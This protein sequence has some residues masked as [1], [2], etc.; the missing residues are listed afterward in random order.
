MKKSFLSFILITAFTVLPAVAQTQNTE[1]SIQVNDK[2]TIGTRRAYEC[3][4]LIAHLAGFQEFNLADYQQYYKPYDDYFSQFMKDKRVVNAIS[5]YKKIRNYGFSYDA[6]ANFATYLSSDCHSFRTTDEKILK[7]NIQNRCGDIKELQQVIADFYDATDFE[8]FYQ[9]QLP[10][11]EQIAQY[12]YSYKDTMITGLNELEKYYRAEV[13]GIFI[14]ASFLTGP[15][16]FG[17]SFTDGK[18]TWFEPQYGAGYFDANLFIHELS[19]PF[20]NKA[21]DEIIKNKKIMKLV[22]KDFKGEKKKIMQDQAYGY[23]ETYLYELFNR[24]NTNNILKGFCDEIYVARSI[25]YDKKRRFDEIAEVTEILDRYMLGDYENIYAFLP[26]LEKEYI[27][28]LQT[29]DTKPKPFKLSDDDTSSFVFLGKTY[30]AEYCGMQDLTGF[31]DYVCRKY[32]RLKDAYQNVCN[33]SV[34]DYLP[35]NN[36]PFK[37]NEGEVFR[38]E[39]LK[40]DGTGFIEY[41][42]ADSGDEIN[43]EP[44]T[45]GFYME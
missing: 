35:Y 13:N 24:A 27:N 45:R 8:Y 25:A 39:Y 42:R 23:V 10:V 34:T 18:N 12:L 7:E 3:T 43:G 16:N 21:V 11:Y 29:V 28:I 5:H 38:I 40:K 17:V 19:H 22:K 44:V 41:L 2:I 20:S 15:N 4:A 37:V 33:Y 32:W 9:T 6:I 36:Y 26:E 31:N 30:E 14:S 1:Y